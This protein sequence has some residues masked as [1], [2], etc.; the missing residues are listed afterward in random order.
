MLFLLAAVYAATPASMAVYADTRWVRSPFAVVSAGVVLTP[1]YDPKK[2]PVPWAIFD[3]VGRMVAAED[4]VAEVGDSGMEARFRKERQKVTT[5]DTILTVVAIVVVGGGLSAGGAPDYPT[6]SAGA[7]PE[8]SP[9]WTTI[10][11][12][13]TVSGYYTPE[14]ADELVHK[15][16]ASLRRKLGL[17]IEEA[18]VLDRE[19]VGMRQFPGGVT[20]ASAPVP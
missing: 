11:A 12:N 10:T 14:L 5:K 17:S 1:T 8:T 3:G 19:P 4:F 15:H 20:G 13:R 16:N 7:A 9:A 6:P 18:D 2:A